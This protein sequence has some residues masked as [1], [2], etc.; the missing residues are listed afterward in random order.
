MG[1]TMPFRGA[2]LQA[3]MRQIFQDSLMG[4]AALAQGI[5][6]LVLLPEAQLDHCF[7]S[8]AATSC[9]T[10]PVPLLCRSYKNCAGHRSLGRRTAGFRG[11]AG[12]G[13]AHAAAAGHAAEPAEAPTLLKVSACRSRWSAS[14]SGQASVIMTVTE[15]W[16]GSALQRPCS[17][18]GAG[19]HQACQQGSSQPVS[20]MSSRVVACQLD[21]SLRV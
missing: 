16:V 2:R 13:A 10:Q 3:R 11:R 6:C 15:R 9:R 1:L 17:Q 19:R 12:R 20:L 4:L 8:A 5:L 14:H 18:E 21:S 7:R